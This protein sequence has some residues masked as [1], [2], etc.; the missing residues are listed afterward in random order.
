[1]RYL[2][3]VVCASHGALEPV[4]FEA[5]TDNEAVDKARES[6]IVP[7]E[8]GDYEIV[9]TCLDAS[10]Q[11]VHASLGGVAP[12]PA[13]T[14]ISRFT[15]THEPLPHV[16]E[17]VYAEREA[18]A[19]AEAS[20]AK[21]A[22]IRAEERAKIYAGLGIADPELAELEG[23]DLPADGVERTVHLEAHSRK[24]SK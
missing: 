18:K 1:M 23:H 24:V 5:A 10:T 16:A 2:I 17:K 12:R 20:A 14:E 15:V 22:A 11:I 3:A 6:H 19:L 21:V 4:E 8:G 9:V 7:D 13:N